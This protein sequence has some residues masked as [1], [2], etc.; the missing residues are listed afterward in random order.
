MKPNTK[1]LKKGNGGKYGNNKKQPLTTKF[2]PPDRAGSLARSATIK[3][4]T[5]GRSS[6]DPK[7][8]SKLINIIGQ[9]ESKSIW[10]GS[11]W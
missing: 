1:N 11:Y 8:L 5:E 3:H 6:Y 4:N 9:N 10:K 7:D 2:F